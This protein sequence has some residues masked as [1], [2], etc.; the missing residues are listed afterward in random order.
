MAFEQ[1]V[2]PGR[3][4][5][6]IRAVVARLEVEI[7][8]SSVAVATL[9]PIDREA[10]IT[11]VRSRW[12]VNAHFCFMLDIDLRTGV[13]SIGSPLVVFNPDMAMIASHVLREVAAVGRIPWAQV[14]AGEAP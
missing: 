11:C 10:L 13:V 8:K 2:G 3:A 6:R 14:A 5:N 9:D 4:A 7:A 1:E 12:Y